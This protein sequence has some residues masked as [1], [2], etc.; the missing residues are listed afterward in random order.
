MLKTTQVTG[1]R[2]KCILHLEEFVAA[3][4]GKEKPR[5]N[6]LV[7]SIEHSC[8]AQM[9]SKDAQYKVDFSIDVDTGQLS[10]QIEPLVTP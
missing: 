3:D 7:M 10:Y 4:I 9:P 8:K 1:N 2:R 5:L 6:H